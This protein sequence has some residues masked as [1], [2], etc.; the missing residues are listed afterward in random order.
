MKYGKLDLGQIEAIVNKL[1]GMD[2]VKR[3]LSGE[4]VIQV[5]ESAKKAADGLFRLLVNYDLKVETMVKEGRYDWKN[6][7]INDKN[8]PSK[9]TGQKEIELKLFHFNKAMASE[10]VIKEMDKQGYRPAELPELLALGAK[11]P[12]EQKK[13]PIIALGSVWQDWDGGRYVA[14]LRLG[15]SERKLGLGC[16]G[17]DWGEGC[18]FAAVS[19]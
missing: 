1:G 17:I 6:D 5:K 11:H 8:F 2:G 18:R 13:Y 4:L 7:D 14:Y 9:R 12:D 10:D 3:F 15:G 16:Y 19:K